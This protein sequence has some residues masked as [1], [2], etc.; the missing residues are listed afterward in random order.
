MMQ[1]RLKEQTQHTV[2]LGSIQ[3]P[4]QFSIPVRRSA[5][6]RR[7]SSLNSTKS[8]R[9]LLLWQPLMKGKCQKENESNNITLIY[10]ANSYI[11][12]HTSNLEILIH[13]NSGNKVE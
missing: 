13:C 1:V 6:S 10:A 8:P 2:A 5:A 7:V 4:L 9:G 3:P 11:G 12:L